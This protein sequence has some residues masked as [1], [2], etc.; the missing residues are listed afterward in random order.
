MSEKI[1]QTT[2]NFNSL[3]GGYRTPRFSLLVKN[4]SDNIVFFNNNG[5]LDIFLLRSEIEV[6]KTSS[7]GAIVTKHKAF[8]IEKIEGPEK[9]T[10]IAENI[11]RLEKLA[12]LDTLL[13]SNASGDFR[14]I[15]LINSTKSGENSNFLA[16]LL[17]VQIVGIH[18]HTQRELE[19]KTVVDYFVPY[20]K[21]PVGIMTIAALAA[22]TKKV[23]ETKSGTFSPAN[24][25]QQEPEMP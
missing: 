12:S 13:T 2:A 3:S 20:D 19:G 8:V 7:S 23:L 5:A 15:A 18:W 1:S 17:G 25:P 4:A 22:T 21:E 14:T 24:V 6:T 11:K 16:P 10:Y 9:D